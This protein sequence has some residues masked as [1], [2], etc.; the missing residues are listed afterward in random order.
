MGAAVPID[1]VGKDPLRCRHHQH[2]VF[3]NGSGISLHGW[4][5]VGANDRE[6]HG[7]A[8]DQSA[9]AG[10]IDEGGLCLLPKGECLTEGPVRREGILAI[11]L[12]FQGAVAI[13]EQGG[14]AVGRLVHAGN[15][16][17]V[18]S[19]SHHHQAELACFHIAVVA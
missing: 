18:C 15:I 16:A 9:I 8:G 14:R 3:G 19:V 12:H 5:V 4:Q 6:G 1:I 10:L 17:W 2:G 13:A 7:A 11:G